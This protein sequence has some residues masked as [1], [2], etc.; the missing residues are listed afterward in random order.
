[1]ALSCQEEIEVVCL[2]GFKGGAYGMHP[3]KAR[4]L[5][6]RKAGTDL[7]FNIKQV[8]GRWITKKGV[9]RCYHYAVVDDADNYAEIFL[10]TSQMRWFIKLQ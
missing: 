10:D 4:L 7:V 8:T 2:F 9:F 1:M 5:G 6:H 3:L